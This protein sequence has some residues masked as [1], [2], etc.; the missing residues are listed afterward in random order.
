MLQRRDDDLTASCPYKVSERSEAVQT[1]SLDFNDHGNIEHTRK[2]KK[3]LVPNHYCTNGP[4][5][6]HGL[7]CKTRN[8][9]FVCT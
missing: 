9:Q 6:E 4:I 8:A 3:K 2:T 7:A 5:Q 1:G